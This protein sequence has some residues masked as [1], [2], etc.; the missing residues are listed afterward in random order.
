MPRLKAARE[1]L[2]QGRLERAQFVG[3]AQREVEEAAVDRAQFDAHRR[4]GAAPSVAART[5]GRRSRAALA[6]A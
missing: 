2:A 3:Q 1:Q 4:R 5:V 6:L